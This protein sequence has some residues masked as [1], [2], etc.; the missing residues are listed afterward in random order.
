[1]DI[2]ILHCSSLFSFAQPSISLR[3]LMLTPSGTATFSLIKSVIIFSQNSAALIISRICF[4]LI[5]VNPRANETYTLNPKSGQLYAMDNIQ[6]NGSLKY[7]ANGGYMT[8]FF[9][10]TA[11]WTARDDYNITFNDHCDRVMFFQNQS[12]LGA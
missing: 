10:C 11:E 4:K 7:I 6:N 8:A 1:M 3:T 12:F 9:A 2:Q 5:S